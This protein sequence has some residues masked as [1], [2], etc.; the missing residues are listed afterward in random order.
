MNFGMRKPVRK[1]ENNKIL[2]T[3]QQTFLRFFADSELNEIFRLSGGTALSAFYL[4][5]RL[6]DDLDFFSS[7]KIPFY[8]VENFLKKL[9]FV[10]K[11]NFTKICD[12]KIFTLKLHDNSLL[13]TEFTFYPLKNIKTTNQSGLLRID[14]LYDI[15]V[16]K[17]CAIADR[18][19]V[20]DYVD[21]Y[22][23][24]KDNP[25]SLHEF[26]HAAENKCEITGIRNILESR[27]L[28]IPPG[29]EKLSLK[30]EISQPE[31]E[32]YFTDFVKKLAE[33]R[34]NNT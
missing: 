26:I 34:L 18:N 13:K 7:E 25:D 17:L 3:W 24:V 2:T 14:S 16:N 8:V 21:V 30:T 27:L 32:K 6:S 1:I 28:Q 12:R 11:I 20:K 31:M 4:E 10:D 9:N 22:C 5:H 23:A 15:I 29:I 19:D 33:N